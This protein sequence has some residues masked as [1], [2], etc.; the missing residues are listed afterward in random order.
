[1]FEILHTKLK[2]NEIGREGQAS[3]HKVSSVAMGDTQ[4]S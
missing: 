2:L 1:M 3:E 4:D